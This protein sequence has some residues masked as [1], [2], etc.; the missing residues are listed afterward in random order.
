M[1]DEEKAEE[2]VRNKADEG[3]FD[4]EQFGKAYFSE[5]SMKQAFLAG[6][7]TGRK[8]EKEYVKNNAFTSMKEQGL[9]PFDKWHNLLNNPIDLPQCEEDEQIIFY[10]KEWYEDIKKYRKHYCLGFY[11]KSSWNDDVKVFVEKSK[12]YE[13]E[14]L[15][16]TV[17]RW[18]VLEMGD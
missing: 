10:V 13:N 8:T 3:N 16:A 12:G 15:P 9:F 5:S 17:L 11:K 4:L 1:T 14:H 6:L 18:R 2:Y 7:K